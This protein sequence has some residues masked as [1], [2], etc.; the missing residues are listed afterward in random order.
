MYHDVLRT[1]IGNIYPTYLGVVVDF[2]ENNTLVRANLR[3]G[4][5]ML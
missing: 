4:G 2:V 5:W 3:L 1:M